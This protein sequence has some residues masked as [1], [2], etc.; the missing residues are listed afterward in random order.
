MLRLKEIH[1]RSVMQSVR[2]LR[3]NGE[4]GAGCILI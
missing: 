4:V 2:V 3:T 1:L